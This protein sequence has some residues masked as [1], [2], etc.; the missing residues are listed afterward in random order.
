MNL[1]WRAL[2]MLDRIVPSKIAQPFVPNFVRSKW[3]EHVDKFFDVADTIAAGKDEKALSQRM[4]LTA[5]TIR[6]ISAFIAYIR[7]VWA[8][9]PQWF[10]SFQSIE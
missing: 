4:A 5:F 9:R 3:G 2:K 6:I 8:F 10:V 1:N 7:L